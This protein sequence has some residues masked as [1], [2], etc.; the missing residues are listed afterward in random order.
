MRLS[1]QYKASGH[2][3]K[4]YTPQIFQRLFEQLGARDEETMK[5]RKS[6]AVNVHCVENAT[7]DKELIRPI[8][9]ERA[10]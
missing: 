3:K 8:I 2:S 5:E 9:E 1:Y 4:H 7:C 6:A 10:Q